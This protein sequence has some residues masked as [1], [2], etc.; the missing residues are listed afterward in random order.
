MV[1]VFLFPR[2]EANFGTA[3][4][5]GQEVVPRIRLACLGRMSLSSSTRM[6]RTTLHTLVKVLGHLSHQIIGGLNSEVVERCILIDRQET[7]PA[8]SPSGWPATSQVSVDIQQ[9]V[10]ERRE[11]GGTR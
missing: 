1:G 3:I 9:A 4:A 10:L 7:R 11:C 8:N 2:E 5:I 6:C